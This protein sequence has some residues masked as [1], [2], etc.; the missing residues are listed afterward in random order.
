MSANAPGQD[1]F[2]PRISR[3]APMAAAKMPPISNQMDL[4]VGDPVNN[5]EKSELSEWEA[6]IP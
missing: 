5:R 1:D 2:C 6:L 3:P 4:L